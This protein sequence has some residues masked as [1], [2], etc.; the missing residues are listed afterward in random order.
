MEREKGCAGV[1]LCYMSG[2]F[3]W[4]KLRSLKVRQR[5]LEREKFSGFCRRSVWM[6]SSIC[7][8]EDGRQGEGG[9]KEGEIL[10][11]KLTVVHT[12]KSLSSQGQDRKE[13]EKRERES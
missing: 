1:S 9:E 6:C 2:R 13:R 11:K 12:K 4:H 3:T 10:N 8:R 7:Y 5:E